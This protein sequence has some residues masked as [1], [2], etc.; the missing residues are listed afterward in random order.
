MSK[1]FGPKEALERVQS[2]LDNGDT[3]LESLKEV[4]PAKDV[5]ADASNVELIWIA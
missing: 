4:S 3:K 1:A 5:R 2:L